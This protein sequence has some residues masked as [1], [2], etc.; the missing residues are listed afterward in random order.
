MCVIK[1]DVP[2]Q[3]QRGI[4]WRV[5]TPLRRKFAKD[6]LNEDQEL[7]ESESDLS[8]HSR[9]AVS[10]LK[11]LLLPLHLKPSPLVADQLIF[12]WRKENP[13]SLETLWVYKHLS[14]QLKWELIWWPNN[15]FSSMC[16][17][18]LE[19][20]I[21]DMLLLKVSTQLFTCSIYSLLWELCRLNKMQAP[22]CMSELTYILWWLSCPN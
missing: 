15:S 13:L 1:G 18:D 22:I 3:L 20:C 5:I 2:G 6:T 11:W 16:S 14:R 10:I 7:E 17:I 9:E 12:P 8:K 4:V 21:E 19:T